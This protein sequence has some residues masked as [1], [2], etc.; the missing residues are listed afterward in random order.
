MAIQNQN[1]TII[2]Q[3]INIT[4][5]LLMMTTFCKPEAGLIIEANV[6]YVLNMKFQGFT[7]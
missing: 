7:T 3:K 4:L 6:I 1:M 5:V 2:P